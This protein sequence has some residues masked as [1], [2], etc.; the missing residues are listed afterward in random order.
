M[1]YIAR[2]YWHICIENSVTDSLKPWT[3][4]TSGEWRPGIWAGRGQESF[5]CTRIG[6]N[7][8]KQVYALF[9]CDKN[10]LRSGES[11][12]KMMPLGMELYYTNFRIC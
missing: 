10:N 3:A 6:T 7:L 8:F 12:N 4:V 2:G 5:H 9:S 11:L 1:D